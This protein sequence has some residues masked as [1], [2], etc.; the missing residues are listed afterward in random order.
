MLT[1]F[2]QVFSDILN[3]VHPTTTTIGIAL[4]AES[5]QLTNAFAQR[6]SLHDVN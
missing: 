2:L 1:T 4:S 6:V 5:K 3:S